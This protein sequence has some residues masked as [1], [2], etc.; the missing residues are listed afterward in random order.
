MRTS[1]E[2]FYAKAG[3]STALL[4]SSELH[5]APPV[6]SDEP[7]TGMQKAKGGVVAMLEVIESDFSRMEA[8][9]TASEAASKKEF[10]SF[11]EESKITKAEKSKEVEHKTSSKQQKK[12][13]LIT[14][15]ADLQGTEKELDAAEVYFEKLKP[16]CLDARAPATRGALIILYYT[17]LYYSI[18]YY[19]I[20]YYTILYYI[21]LYY[22]ILLLYYTILYYIILYYTILYYC[23]ACEGEVAA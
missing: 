7:Y 6:F 18:L 14:L 13:E 22:T 8:E 16:D 4:Q 12:S 10:E 11:V 23:I 21:I 9:A 5:G 15:Q 19:T 17:I 2:D 3:Q 1:T 20:L